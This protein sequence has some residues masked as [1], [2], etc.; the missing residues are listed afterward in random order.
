MT[1]ARICK[2]P[3][4]KPKV[5][6]SFYQ[7]SYSL[8]ATIDGYNEI[9]QSLKIERGVQRTTDYL[10][11]NPL[12]QDRIIELQSVKILQDNKLHKIENQIFDL[13]YSL[14]KIRQTLNTMMTNEI[15]LQPKKGDTSHAIIKT[16]VD[17]L[18]RV[19]S[20]VPDMLND[21]KI[22]TAEI[23]SWPSPFKLTRK[24]SVAFEKQ[25][26]TQL[27]PDKIIIE[28][29]AVTATLSQIKNV[30][31][32]NREQHFRADIPTGITH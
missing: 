3:Y 21:H 17:F 23:L 7:V 2:Y 30:L 26:E 5:P 1:N 22:C 18:N 29:R 8:Q 16:H 12:S 24:K 27:K 10:L 9:L 19:Q 13:T 20:L 32:A 11:S 15:T 6:Q 31:R 28:L 4:E 14:Q 25:Q